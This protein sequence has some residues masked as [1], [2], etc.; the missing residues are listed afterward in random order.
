MAPLLMKPLKQLSELASNEDKPF[1]LA[2]GVIKPHLPFGAPKS[3]YDRYEGVE[4]PAIQNPQ[5]PKGKTT[6][7]G[8]GGVYGIQPLG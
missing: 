5:R 3:Y 7:H 8:S 2:V 1:F 4:L 6:W